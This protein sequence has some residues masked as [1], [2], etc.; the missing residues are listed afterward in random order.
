MSLSPALGSR[1]GADDSTGVAQAGKLE[2]AIKSEDPPANND[3][4]VTILTAKTF[5]ELVFGKPRNVFVEFYAP[6]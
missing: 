3:G 4:P 2:R 6:W 1:A 5:D